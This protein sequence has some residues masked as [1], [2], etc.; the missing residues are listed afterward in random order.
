MQWGAKEKEEFYDGLTK[1]GVGSWKAMKD[2]Y[3]SL[4]P[5]DLRLKLMR[6]IGRQ[7]LGEYFGLRLTEADVA[8]QFERNQK[9]GREHKH[10]WKNGMI[11]KDEQG[12]AE[13]LI[14]ETEGTLTAVKKRTASAP[15][16]PQQPKKRKITS[17]QDED[18]AG[19]SG[20]EASPR[21]KQAS[22]KNSN[23]E[24]NANGNNTNGHHST[25]PNGTSST[26]NGNS[27]T[28]STAT[29]H[30]HNSNENLL[31]SAGL[32]KDLEL[33]DNLF[34]MGEDDPIVPKDFLSED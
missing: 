5:H 20:G 16:P 28:T 11:V 19:T 10:L 8:A 29:H 31:P 14:K 12:T 17:L 2:H 18:Q 26:M 15:P 13:R 23:L 21:K 22:S 34:L 25:T 1:F 6:L 24:N 27:N 30:H 4:A 3:N 33:D 9:I 7:D 32:E